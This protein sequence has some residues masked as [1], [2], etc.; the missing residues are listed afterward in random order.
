MRKNLYIFILLLTIL[1]GYGQNKFILDD[2]SETRFKLTDKVWPQT[3]GEASVC[4][5]N[6]DKLSAFTIT[7]DDNNEQDIPFWI[8]LQEKYALKFTWFVI[9]E[10]DEKQNVKNWNLFNQL[11]NA[12]NA[13][14]GHD[15][16]NWYE[17]K[18]KGIKFPSLKKYNKRIECTI[19]TI[20]KHMKG[21]R[22]LTYAYP[23]GEGNVDEVAKHFISS[24]GVIGL[25]N[26][27]NQIDFK[28][29][30]SVSNPHI[31]VND[32]TR[33]RYILPL[34]DETTKLEG[35]NYY[36]GWGSTHFH[37][38]TSPEAQKTTDE[39]LNYLKQKE[40][41]LWIGTFP[42]IAKYAQ[43][44]AT[45]TIKVDSVSETIISFNLTD[46]MEDDIYDFPL[47]V[48]IRLANNWKSF[49]ATQNG[50]VI[51]SK[52]ITR[53][54]YKYALIKVVPDRGQV[55]L[56]GDIAKKNVIFNL[57]F[58]KNN[59][60]VYTDHNLLNDVGEVTWKLLDERATIEEDETYGKV[61]KVKYPK[62]AVGPKQGGIQFD[63]PL[64]KANE[65]FLEYNMKFEEGFDFALGG[66]LPGL[67][68]GGEK[69]T[70]GVHPDNGEGWSARYM[71]IADGEIIV[72]FYHMDMEHKWGD[73][74]KLNVFFKPGQWYHIKQRIKLN[75]IDKFNGIMEVWV[76]EKKALYNDDVRY[77]LAPLGEI[78]SF[79]FS[80]F[81]GGNTED[82]APKKDSYIYFDNFKVS[83]P[84]QN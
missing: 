31:Y 66:K 54:H 33:N 76:D 50:K 43:E 32:S 3:I 52:T 84:K 27:A 15:D 68:S 21:Q 14:Q 38:V 22:C 42:D 36:R 64:P 74:V 59:I 25:L 37:H 79:Y 41:K 7:I 9:T 10:A 81:H 58:K 17:D 18:E 61:L 13:I 56:T 55:V 71:W 75:D 19:N 51:E 4:L 34:L 60:G 77:R 40:G 16:R 39:F 63:K 26:P 46:E 47:S 24:R 49:S 62:G 2:A 82:W 57:D 67:T 30:R 45:H 28:Q 1:T 29:V 73:T 5:W 8:Q 53:N 23:W 44:Y 83:T 48:K 12:G 80:T 70:G 20:E 72:Y 35:V 11:S 69:Y 78:D 65:Y 6:D